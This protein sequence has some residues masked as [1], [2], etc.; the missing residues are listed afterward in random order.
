V[1]VYDCDR[2]KTESEQLVQSDGFEIGSVHGT[3][4][5]IQPRGERISKSG[6]KDRL[7]LC[8][9]VKCESVSVIS[10]CGLRIA[11][12]GNSKRCRSCDKSVNVQKKSDCRHHCPKCYDLP[13]RRPQSK[14]CKCGERYEPDTFEATELDAHAC[15]DLWQYAARELGPDSFAG[16]VDWL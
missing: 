1:R 8:R 15:A 5:V 13:H 14:P 7:Y 6:R 9:C 3:Q 4:M 2:W 16:I 10:E 11:D 12:H